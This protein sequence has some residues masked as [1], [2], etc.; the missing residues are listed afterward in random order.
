M[1]EPVNMTIRQFMEYENIGRTLAYQLVNDPSFY[2]AFRIGKRKIL[3][4][5]EKLEKWN[6]EQTK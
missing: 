6:E 3:I 5:R 1:S 2:P 4:N